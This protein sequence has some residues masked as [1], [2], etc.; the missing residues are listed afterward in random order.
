MY[1]ADLGKGIKSVT[2]FVVKLDWSVRKTC[3]AW[4]FTQYIQL[5]IKAVHSM[6]TSD[7]ITNP[8]LV[9]KQQ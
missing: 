7:A 3:Q 9:I 1:Q 8:S 6:I 4:V 2:I 5:R